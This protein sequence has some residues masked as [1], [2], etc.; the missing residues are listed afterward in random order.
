MDKSGVETVNGNTECEDLK[1]TQW[2]DE[3]VHRL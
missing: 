1:N 3:T 2:L